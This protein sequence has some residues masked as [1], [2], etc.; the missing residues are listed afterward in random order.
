LSAT[1][2]LHNISGDGTEDVST[3]ILGNLLIETNKI[4]NIDDIHAGGGVGLLVGLLLGLLPPCGSRH[5]TGFHHQF[6]LVMNY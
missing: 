3:R 5:L 6:E 2:K 4:R 1:E